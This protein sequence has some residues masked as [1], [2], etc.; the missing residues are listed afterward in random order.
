MATTPTLKEMRVKLTL[1][2]WISIAALSISILSGAF[3]L[4]VVY[5]QV[6]RNTS[7]IDELKHLPAD[8]A[9][10]KANVAFLTELAR[11]QRR[12]GQ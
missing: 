7:D 4:G 1:A 2:E 9:E 5:G 10:I 8:V 11:E 6:Q 12:R 3:T